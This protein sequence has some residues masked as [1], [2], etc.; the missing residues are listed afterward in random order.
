[1]SVITAENSGSDNC[2]PVIKGSD[3]RSTT[4]ANLRF[5]SVGQRAHDES[6]SLSSGVW[7]VDLME[8]IS[9]LRIFVRGESASD[10][11]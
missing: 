8:S 7:G 4:L 10:R 11:E 1:M 6:N 5:L 3:F 2:I 9:D